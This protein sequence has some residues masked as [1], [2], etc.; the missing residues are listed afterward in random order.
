[1]DVLIICVYLVFVSVLMLVSG[2]LLEVRIRKRALENMGQLDADR[3]LVRCENRD[4][5]YNYYVIDPVPDKNNNVS[6][7]SRR[8]TRVVKN[9]LGSVS[10]KKVL[11]V[12]S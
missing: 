6:N 4:E 2:Y 11:G 3:P 8:P 7:N 10:R 9:R 1:M 12:N 5:N